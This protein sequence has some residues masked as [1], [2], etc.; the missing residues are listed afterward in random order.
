MRKHFFLLTLGM[1]SSWIAAATKRNLCLW[2]LVD[3]AS[4]Q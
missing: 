2:Q 3:A 4:G 1:S